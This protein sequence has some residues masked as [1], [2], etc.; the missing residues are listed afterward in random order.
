M[1]LISHGPF[2]LISLKKK[3]K[4]LILLVKRNKNAKMFFYV[5]NN[6]NSICL[7]IHLRGNLSKTK[8]DKK[9]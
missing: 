8:K 1:K 5:Y 6:E 4:I 7:K 9:T 2:V 3:L